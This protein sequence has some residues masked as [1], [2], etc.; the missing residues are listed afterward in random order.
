MSGLDESGPAF[1]D[2]GLTKREYF[3]ILI[4]NGMIDVGVRNAWD[5]K[6]MAK[7]AVAM[8]NALIEELNKESE[9]DG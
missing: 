8:A 5:D 2:Y 7:D 9:T 6:S 1:G 3:A 4:L